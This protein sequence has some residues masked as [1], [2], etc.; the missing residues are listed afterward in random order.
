[1]ND[2]NPRPEKSIVELKNVGKT[3]R[4]YKSRIARIKQMLKEDKNN[5]K[6]INALDNISLDLKK[7]TALAIIGKNGSGKSTLL[8]IICNI[9]EP[10]KGS[11]RVDGKIAA[12]LEL[13]SGFNPE[14]TGRENIYLNATLFGLSKKQIE[15]R[16]QQ[17]VEFSEIGEFVDQPTKTY[18]SGMVVRLAFSIITNVDADIL[19]IDEALSVGDAYF[20]QKCM[21][22]I[23]RFRENGTLIFVS[24]DANAVLSLCDQ[25]LLLQNGEKQVLGTPKE[26]MEEYT[27]QLQRTNQEENDKTIYEGET[28]NRKT[29]RVSTN[30]EYK[31]GEDNIERMKWSD[32]RKHAINASKYANFIDIVP[33]G[34]HITNKESY[35]GGKARIIS[36]RIKNE[37]DNTMI[38][39][40]LGGEV[41]ELT[42]VA[43]IEEE[44]TELIIG[45]ILK[46]SKGLALLGDNTLSALPSKKI[47]EATKGDTIKTTFIFTLPLLSRGDYSITAALASGDQINHEI[48][49]WVNDAVILRSRCTSIAAGQAGVPMHSIEVEKL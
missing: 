17:I 28:N 15:A 23:E 32:Y 39:T 19:I 31:K 27:K 41:V 48:L 10:T 36:T 1:M 42:I 5:Y 49:H 6:E 25:A 9:M 2:G 46:N 40:I 47:G 30:P 7:G 4:I 35:G 33:I 43:A 20:T 38:E 26:V 29:K 11:V 22:F 12:L 8:Q 18:S 44:I 16:I 45:F 14:F 13:G 3:F 37:E 21:R 24:H 34:I